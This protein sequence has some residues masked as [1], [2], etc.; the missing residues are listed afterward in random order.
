MTWQGKTIAFYPGLLLCVVSGA[1]FHFLVVLSWGAFFEILASIYLVPVISF[2]IHNLISPLQYGL[3]NL[4]EQKYSSW[5]GG[6]QIQLIYAVCPFFERLLRVIP[7]LYSAWLRMWGSKVGK[8]VYWTPQVEL[9]DRGSMI[10]GDEVIFGQKVECYCHIIK[11]KAE[12]LRLYTKPITIGNRVFLGAGT[13]IGP[14]V[15]IDDGT[16]VPL[17]SDLLVNQQVGED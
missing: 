11:P 8:N 14:G 13:R 12:V 16:F 15:K 4:S 10:I 17:L 2:R 5:W 3:N 9:Y 6:H 1:V 7:G